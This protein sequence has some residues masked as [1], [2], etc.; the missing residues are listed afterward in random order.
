MFLRNIQHK[1]EKDCRKRAKFWNK[2]NKHNFKCA[3][4]NL[5]EN[6][7]L[8]RYFIWHYSNYFIGL[9]NLLCKLCHKGYYIYDIDN[10]FAVLIAIDEVPKN[11]VNYT[12]YNSITKWQ[13]K[14]DIFGHI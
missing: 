4:K 1:K 2:L 10:G 11:A 8:H 14:T 13:P 12:R 9:E 5:S 7:P 3:V 6:H